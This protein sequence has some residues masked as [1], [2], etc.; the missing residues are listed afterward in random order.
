MPADVQL[1]AFTESADEEQQKRDARAWLD[2]MMAHRLPGDVRVR[3]EALD[4][5]DKFVQK[6]TL[7]VFKDKQGGLRELARVSRLYGVEGGKAA[8]AVETW[9][10]GVYRP[11]CSLV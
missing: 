4:V 3:F 11:H 7:R 5:G 6:L 1:D 2:R 10:D 8:D 9:L